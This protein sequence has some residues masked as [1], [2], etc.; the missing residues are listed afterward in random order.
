[1]LILIFVSCLS[2]CWHTVLF[3]YSKSWTIKQI[4]YSMFQGNFFN[5]LSKP[6]YK[7]DA[8]SKKRNIEIEIS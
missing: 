6:L 1:M 3:Y 7:K 5:F 8:N 4:F 2:G